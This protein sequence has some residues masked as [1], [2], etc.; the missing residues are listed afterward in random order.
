MVKIKNIGS[1]KFKEYIKNKKVIVFGAG[2]SFESC[3]EIYFLDKDI[4]IVVDNNPSLW[5]HYFSLGSKSFR[6]ISV[7]DLIKKVQQLD[8]YV[9]FISSVFYAAEIIDQLDKIPELDGL[10]CF[11]EL[12]IRNTR[13]PI[14]EYSF[15]KGQRKIPRKLHYVW[16]G[17]KELPTEFKENIETWKHFNPNFEIIRW[18]ENNLTFSDC[19]YLREAYECKAWGF[20]SNYIRLK[21]I[22]ENGGIYLDTDVEAISSFDKLLNDEAFFNMGC[23]NRINN[24]CGFGAVPGNEVIGEMLS[25]YDSIHYVDSNGKQKKQQ[26]H[27]ILNKILRKNGFQIINQYS[28]NENGVVIYPSEVMSPLTISGFPDMFSEKTVS[29]HKEHGSWKSVIEKEGLKKTLLLIRR[30]IE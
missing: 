27:T 8:D 4:E 15:S 7:E 6:I 17:K 21:V 14:K 28:K 12:F 19:D 29:I 26:A 3:V 30:I 22:Y 18:D 16:L 20:A 11:L 25:Y 24:G 2:R 1:T 13:E 9:C 23:A 5:G 10:E